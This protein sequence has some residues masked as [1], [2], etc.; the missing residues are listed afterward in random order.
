M[1]KGYKFKLEPTK[2]Q[3][4]LINKT[5]GCCRW[6]YNNALDKKSKAFE[7]RKESIGA[8][9]LKNRLPYLKQVKPWLKEVDSTALQQAIVHLDDAYTNF[10]A[11]RSGLPKFKSKHNEVHS[12]KTV[13]ASLRVVDDKHINLPILGVVRCRMHRHPKGVIKSA[14]ITRQAGNYYISL[15]CEVDEPDKLPITTNV[16]GIDLGI[17]EFAVDSNGLVYEN[18]KYLSKSLNKLKLEQEK[19]SRMTKGSNNYKKQREKIAKLHLH[20]SN[21]RLDHA[22]KLSTKLIRE[23][24][25]ISIEDLDIKGMLKKHNTATKTRDKLDNSKARSILD[26][27][28]GIFTQLLEYKAQWYGRELIKIDRYTPTSQM[29]N[30]CK[31]INPA[32]KDLSVRSWICP[33]CNTSHN[34]D[35]N[36]AI[37]ILE[38][39][40][41]KAA[42]NT[43]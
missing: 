2:E 10:F 43:K 26:A 42:S 39:G 6:V 31:T 3:A 20:I 23:N 19:L 13:S 29:C 17:K 15:L 8:T 32:V 28:W 22:H 25:I 14:T 24:Q 38:E 36:A 37:N 7:R 5:L 40:L 16:I 18:P 9:A 11:G 27:G 12:Y 1:R 35:Y 4:V 33:N 41:K 30:H 34:R 21:Q